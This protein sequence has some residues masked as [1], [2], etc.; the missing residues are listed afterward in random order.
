MWRGLGIPVRYF[1]YQMIIRALI[2][3]KDVVLPVKEI[4]L[5]KTVVRLSYLHNGISYPGKMTSFNWISLKVV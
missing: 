4:L 5:Y 3:Y 1:D 2:Q